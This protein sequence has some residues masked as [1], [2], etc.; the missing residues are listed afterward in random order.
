MSK[1]NQYPAFADRV[2]QRWKK[3]PIFIVSGWRVNPYKPEQMI[4]FVLRSSEEHF[5][6]TSGKLTFNYETDVLE[7]YSDEE[8]TLF[9]NA[10]RGI[11]ESGFLVPMLEAPTQT[12]MENAIPD[13]GVAEIVQLRRIDEFKDALQRITSKVTLQ[14]ILEELPDNKAQ[15]FYKAVVNRMKEV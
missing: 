7:L 14:R 2:V 8:C 4:T 10:N 1:H 5:D 6:F 12:N 15:S 11:I 13:E 3:I 9:R